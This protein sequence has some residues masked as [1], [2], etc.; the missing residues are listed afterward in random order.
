MSRLPHAASWYSAT[1]TPVP[2]R[3]ALEGPVECDVCVIGAGYTGLSAALHLAERGY[4]VVL[5]EAQR[6]GWGASGRNGGQIVTGFNPS[7]GTLARLVGREDAH[8]L[9]EMS[10]EAKALIA[11]RVARHAIDCDLRWGYLFAATKQRHERDLAAIEREWRED[12]GYAKA[13]RVG[14]DEVRGL[15]ASERYLGGLLDEGSGQLHP[16]N[17]ALGLARAAEAVG[18]RIFEG[19]PVTEIERG[20]RPAAI[21]PGGRVTARYLAIAANARADSVLP[22]LGARIMPVSTYILTT[23]PLGEARARALIPSG[24]AV[25]DVNFV[26]NYYR[27]TSD[28]RMLFGGGVSYSGRDMPGLDSA[29]RR[30][31]LRYFPQLA[32]ARTEFFWGGHVAITMNRTPQ[33]GRVDPNIL[34]AQGYSGHGVALAGL[35]GK[36]IAEAV[37]GTAERF[38]VFARIPHARFPGGHLRT[39][40]LV[41]AMAWYRLRDLL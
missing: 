22:E 21:T 26:L 39:P 23:E 12:L 25:A 20:P 10:E 34:F 33:F 13:R 19:S 28:H 24:L 11:E 32:D 18:V 31:M 41:A 6:V 7:I 3:P 2:D 15:V 1:A 9:W 38:D 14:A 37:A 40:L 8:R 36:L 16:L 4:S 35:G 30:T 27:L 17:Y 29:L 5:L